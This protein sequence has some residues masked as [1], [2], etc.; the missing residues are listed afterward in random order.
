[1]AKK[2]TVG[3]PT[4]LPPSGYSSWL[5][6]AVATLDDR[7]LANDHDW[8]NQPQWPAHVTREEIRTAARAELRQIEGLWLDMKKAWSGKLETAEVSASTQIRG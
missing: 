8:G 1:M 3:C 6:Y 2:K 4:L 5:A 7:S